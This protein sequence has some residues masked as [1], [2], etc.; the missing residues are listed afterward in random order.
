M[1]TL[2]VLAASK[3]KNEDARPHI[4]RKES[5]YASHGASHA[6]RA[7]HKASQGASHVSHGASHAGLRAVSLLL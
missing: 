4:R 2:C 7:S 3:H 1:M 5:Y 6:S